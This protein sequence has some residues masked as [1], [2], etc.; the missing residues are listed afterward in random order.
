M[1]KLTF[2][3]HLAATLIDK[4]HQFS[5]LHPLFPPATCLIAASEPRST[6]HWL[7]G[8]PEPS[9]IWTW[10]IQ[11][12]SSA[13]CR[14]VPGKDTSLVFVCCMKRLMLSLPAISALREDLFQ[15]CIASNYPNAFTLVWGDLWDIFLSLLEKRGTV[16]ILSAQSFLQ[17]PGLNIL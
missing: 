13:I 17:F 12:V 2:K 7:W 10:F 5:L 15:K 11:E 8:H 4:L 1:K 6:L 14:S 9:E 16:L 3:K